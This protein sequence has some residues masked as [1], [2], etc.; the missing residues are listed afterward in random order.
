MRTFA[1]ITA[2]LIALATWPELSHISVH[3]FADPIDAVSLGVDEDVIDLEVSARI[4]GTW[5]EWTALEIEKEFDPLLRESNLVMFPESVSK[6]RV[7]G[8]QE[9]AVHPIRV[10]KDPARIELA[11]RYP[12]GAPVILSRR[13][14]GANDAFLVSG[15]ETERS[16][17]AERQEETLNGAYAQRLRECEE[18]KQRYPGEFR[19][20]KTV[21]RDAMGRELRWPQ[22]FSPEV[23]LLVVHHTA[24]KVSGDKRSTIERMRALYEYHA[25]SRGW[26]DIGYHYVI[27]ERGQIY[28]GRAGGNSVVGGHAYCANVGTIGIALMGNFEVE[29]PTMVQMQRL[30]W[31]LSHLGQKYR[32]SLSEDVVFHGK[33]MSS[34]VGHGTLVATQCPGYYIRETLSQVERHVLAGN[35]DSRVIFPKLGRRLY[36]G[37]R[38]TDASRRI[39]QLFGRKVAQRAEHTLTP[40]GSTSVDGEPGGEVTVLVNVQAGNKS[41]SRRSRIATVTRS[42]PRIGVWQKVQDTKQRVV[43][44]LILPQ[45]LYAGGKETLEL[46]VQLPSEEGRHTLTVGSITFTLNVGDVRETPRTAPSAIKTQER[47]QKETKPLYRG[48]TRNYLTSS[49][50]LPRTARSMRSGDRGASIRIR[51]GYTGDSAE[52]R[53]D[54]PPTI[55]GYDSRDRFVNV[56]K[57]GDACVTRGS[58]IAVSTG[59]VRMNPGQGIATIATWPQSANRFRGVIE[60]RVIDGEL[61][62]INELPLEDY[63]AGL[64]EEPDTEPYEKQRA[65]AIATRSYAAFYRDPGNRKFPGKPYD[66]DDSPARF[67]KYGGVYFEEKNPG[68]VKAAQSTAGFVIKKSGK[69]V[70]TPYFST[71]DGKTR[72]PEERGW[73]GFP[74]SEV[75]QSKPDPWCKGMELWGHGVGMSGCGS[76]GQALQGKSAEEILRYYY[77]TTTIER[78]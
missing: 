6:I 70:K 39:S 33:S 54:S 32:M 10:S 64:A 26:G 28:E 45:T 23:K 15:P 66:G 68:W 38:T 61:V 31:L 69:I 46:H 60:C 63:I 17:V 56:V 18:A 27:D 1:V 36:R 11:S 51:L 73:T 22:R 50:L 14:W 40:G 67:Q 77:P 29:K 72:S 59:V 30:Q 53:F 44:E 75:F 65:F 78:L 49:R 47:L 55:N 9:Y 2:F 34:I 41:L 8:T 58:V 19:V 13:Q 74:F 4:D 62:L 25:N 20:I 21:E 57:Q 3:T 12:M 71:D 43:K 24:L 37:Q 52:V 76:K 16:D 42:S 35:L 5:T 48:R 7:R